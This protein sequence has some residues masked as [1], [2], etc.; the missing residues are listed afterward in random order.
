V[1]QIALKQIL[2]VRERVPSLLIACLL[3]HYMEQSS[4]REAKGVCELVK[5]SRY[6][7]ESVSSLTR[8]QQTA[9]CS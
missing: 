2:I 7:R 8:L 6:F 9:S 5:K 3:P 1:R 4:S